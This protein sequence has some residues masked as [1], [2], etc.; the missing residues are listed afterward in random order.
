MSDDIAVKSLLA[1]LKLLYPAF[2]GSVGGAWLHRSEAGIPAFD[3][4]AYRG[5]ERFRRVQEDRRSLGRR[6]YFAGDYLISPSVEGRVVSGFRAAADLIADVSGAD[7][8]SRD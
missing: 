5:L 3:V 4:G 8:D 1:D 2:V 6:I 7:P